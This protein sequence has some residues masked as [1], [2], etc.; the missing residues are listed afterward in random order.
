[1]KKSTRNSLKTNKTTLKK[2]NLKKISGGSHAERHVMDPS[3]L[4]EN[5]PVDVDAIIR[6][7]DRGLKEGK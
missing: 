4:R 7:L 3:I 2:E 1:M 5:K 6:S